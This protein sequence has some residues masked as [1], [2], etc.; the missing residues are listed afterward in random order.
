M[1][2]WINRRADYAIRVVLGLAQHPPGT[3]VSA[4][5]LSEEM[6]IPLSLLYSLLK[7]LNR[8]KLV[9]TYPGPKGGLELARAPEDITLRDVVEAMDRLPQVSECVGEPEVCPFAPACPVRRRWARLHRLVL[10]E[11]ENT[12]FADLAAE[13]RLGLAGLAQVSEDV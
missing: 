7:D 10:Q 13:A 12:T 3:R 6:L 5:Q 1:R 8:A 9:R 2:F 4:Q 11:L